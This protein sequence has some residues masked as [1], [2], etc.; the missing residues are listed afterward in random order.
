MKDDKMRSERERIGLL[1][2]YVSSGG[3]FILF[4]LKF[5][6][7]LISHSYALIVDSI[8]SLSDVLTSFVVIVGFKVGAKPPD[9]EHPFGHQR[10]EIVSTLI[11]AILLIV[12]GV[13]FAQ[14]GIKKIIT[15]DKVKVNTLLIVIVLISILIKELMA[16]YSF[17]LSNKIKSNT[18]KADAW[19]HRSDAISSVL[20][21]V[22]IIGVHYNIGWLDGAM[23]I[24]IALFIIYVGFKILIKA[25]DNLIGSAPSQE[26][27]DEIRKLISRYDGVKGVHDIVINSYGDFAI[28]SAHVVLPASVSLMDAHGLIDTIEREVKNKI[29]VTLSIHIDPVDE[30]NYLYKKIKAFL[31][32]LVTEKNYIKE[33][34]DIHLVEHGAI[35]KLYFEMK[36]TGDETIADE[37]KHI[38][39]N[40]FNEIDEVEIEREPQYTY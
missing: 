15:P 20:V 5:I 3:N 16:R 14:S 30:N 1:E 33:I 38:I 34:H 22:A 35:K 29:N 28:G 23:G 6:F 8:H 40:R 19:H 27:I 37:V 10:A 36:Y 32:M 11:I 12:V 7:G 2:G 9:K 21:L 31:D 13:E 39:L 24:V 25:A 26:I 17:M 18:L 4:V